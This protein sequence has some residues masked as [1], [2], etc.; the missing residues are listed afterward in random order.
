MKSLL[1][2]ILILV[3]SISLSADWA[4]YA[5]TDN[6]VSFYDEESLV[7]KDNNVMK[8]WVK[9]LDYK[10]V[11]NL[12]L[13]MENKVLLEESSKK[14]ASGYMPKIF[15][16]DRVYMKDFEL[17]YP[18][19]VFFEIIMEKN[20]ISHPVQVIHKIYGEHMNMIKN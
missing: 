3:P 4:F 12:I 15:N 1:I 5:F 18:S 13:R 9:H 10:T 16:Y 14:K 19:V 2:L 8:L 11:K 17:R 7:T 6:Y 20:L